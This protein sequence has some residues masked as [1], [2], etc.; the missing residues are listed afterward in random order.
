MAA[1]QTTIALRNSTN[2][3]FRAIGAFIYAGLIAGGW[4]RVAT[5]ID[6]TTVNAPAQNAFAGY[7]V[8]KSPDEVGLTNFYLKLRHGSNNNAAPS[9]C[10]EWSVS[11]GWTAGS[12]LD[13]TPTTAVTSQAGTT[14]GSATTRLCTIAA[15][16]GYLA[17]CLGGGVATI[18][19]HLLVIERT[20]D[21]NL[22]TQDEL[23]IASVY[24]NQTY[25]NANKVYSSQS[26]EYSNNNS[27]II[28]PSWYVYEGSSAATYVSRGTVPLMFALPRGLGRRGPMENY[29]GCPI[30]SLGQ[31]GEQVTIP[32]YGVNRTFIILTATTGAPGTW[33]SGGATTTGLIRFD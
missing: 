22:D 28:S 20:R 13:G 29:L 10:W 25:T 31:P 7:E 14:A 11:W 26:F 8:W 2:A 3:E 23:A 21:E 19:G 17:L 9:Y 30:S 32:V 15:G 6:W 16:T 1:S 27:S 12:T 33:D 18:G 4:T 5:D 24:N